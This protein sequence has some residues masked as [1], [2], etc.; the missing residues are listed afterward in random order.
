MP[1]SFCYSL[2]FEDISYFFVNDRVGNVILLTLFYSH[3]F[4]HQKGNGFSLES[5][6]QQLDLPVPPPILLTEDQH[7]LWLCA[8]AQCGM[9]T[10]I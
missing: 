7:Q 4:S 1:L 8:E 9:K 10:V 3:H 5:N 6:E 2:K